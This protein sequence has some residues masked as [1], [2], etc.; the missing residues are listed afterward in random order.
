LYHR[1]AIGKPWLAE[2][3]NPIGKH[4]LTAIQES[5]WK[6]LA[7]Q[8][9]NTIRKLWLVAIQDSYQGAPARCNTGIIEESLVHCNTGLLLGSTGS[10]KTGILLE[11]T[12][13]LQYMNT[14]GKHWLTAIQEYY[15]EALA[16]CNTGIPLGRTGSLQYWNPI[17]LQYCNTL[18]SS[19]P[20][21]G[22]VQRLESFG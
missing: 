5:Y 18:F 14:I 17:E 12:G 6:A 21:I 2:Y 13:S 7:L 15:W 22:K 20:D 8:Y 11:R 19:A 9:R 1:N 16:R 3:R 10:R 4:L